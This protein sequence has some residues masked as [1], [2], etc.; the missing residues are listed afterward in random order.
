MSNRAIFYISK[1]GSRPARTEHPPDRTSRVRSG[2]QSEDWF[3]YTFGIY[4]VKFL[5]SVT[6]VL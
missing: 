5:N 2:G 1:V 4:T 3:I 6:I